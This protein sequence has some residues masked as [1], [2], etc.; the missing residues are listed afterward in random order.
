MKNA[1]D[2]IAYAIPVQHMNEH[3]RN[4]PDRVIVDVR[5]HAEKPEPREPNALDRASWFRSR[6]SKLVERNRHPTN[7]GSHAAST[8]QRIE[9][10]GPKQ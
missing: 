9:K 8:A 10:N 4:V 1:Q 7:S 5:G 2:T 6:N 3:T